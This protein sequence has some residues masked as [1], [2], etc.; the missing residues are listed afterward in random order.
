VAGWDRTHIPYTPVQ[1][2][3]TPSQGFTSTAAAYGWAVS[4]S[5]GR[6]GYRGK[7]GGPLPP[8]PAHRINNVVRTHILGI[9]H[10]AFPRSTRTQN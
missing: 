1:G 3:P 2:P 9:S 6:H 10:L 8:P 7:N 4:Q 5:P